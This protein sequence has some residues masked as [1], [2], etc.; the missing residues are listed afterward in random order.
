MPAGRPPDYN[1]DFHPV[2][3][4]RWMSEGLTAVEVAKKWGITT[5]T[6]NEWANNHKE[7][8]LAYR[9][10]REY[11]SAWFLEKGRQGLF[12]EEGVRFDA[13]LLAMMLKYSGVNVDEREIQLPKFAK[14]KTLIEKADVICEAMAKG[15]ITAKEASSMIHV[16]ESAAKLAEGT[17]LKEKLAEIEAKLNAT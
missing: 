9:R 6:I 10:A 3:I 12:T 13:R 7:F 17:E 15:K 14:C 11:C 8:S 2:E 5:R 1:P 16:L 4:I